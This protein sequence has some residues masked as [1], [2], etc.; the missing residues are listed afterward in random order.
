MTRTNAE[1]QLLEKLP[2]LIKESKPDV[3]IVSGV[4][5]LEGLAADQR[6]ARLKVTWVSCS[7]FTL[8]AAMPGIVPCIARHPSICLHPPRGGQVG[9]QTCADFDALIVVLYSIAD[10]DFVAAIYDELL[11]RVDSLGLNEQEL[12]AFVIAKKGLSTQP[13]RV[14]SSAHG[15]QAPMRRRCW[16]T[17]WSKR[18]LT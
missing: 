18:A 11:Q 4:H 5:M 6:K 9:S 2:Q 8:H 10:R 14:F 13:S 15:L 16:P 12:A 1:L 17:D 7:R 3:V